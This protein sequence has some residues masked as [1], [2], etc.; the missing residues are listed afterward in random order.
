MTLRLSPGNVTSADGV[1]RLL[2]VL[3]R[4]FSSSTQSK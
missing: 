2:R 1:E 4:L 3:V